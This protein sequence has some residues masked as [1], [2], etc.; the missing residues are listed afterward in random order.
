[1]R[2][3]FDRRALEGMKNNHLLVFRLTNVLIGLFKMLSVPSKNTIKKPTIRQA[4]LNINNH[5][6]YFEL[7][8]AT[9]GL[10]LQ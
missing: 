10:L 1:L 6:T 7:L 3:N 8:V 9:L 2:N 4:T 5:T